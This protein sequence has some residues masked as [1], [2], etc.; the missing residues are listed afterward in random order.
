M[1]G[2]FLYGGKLSLWLHID[3]YSI[4]S[5]ILSFQNIKIRNREVS[6]ELMVY[7]DTE[8][9]LYEVHL[10]RAQNIN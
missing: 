8:K 9:G 4:L 3:L 1:F 6:V 10:V 7:I 2:L 5:G